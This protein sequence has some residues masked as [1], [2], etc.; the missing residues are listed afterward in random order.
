MGKE[1]SMSRELFVFKIKEIVF[2]IVDREEKVF[3]ESPDIKS[4]SFLLPMSVPGHYDT[5]T[6]SSTFD[7]RGEITVNFSLVKEKENEAT[8]R[9]EILTK[10][11][12]WYYGSI[13]DDWHPMA[14]REEIKHFLVSLKKGNGF[15]VSYS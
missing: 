5:S 9:V 6:A 12:N 4:E 2:K 8:V 13:D 14:D 3:L 15:E 10:S 7:E 11:E 1:N